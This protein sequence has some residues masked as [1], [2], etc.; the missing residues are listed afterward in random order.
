MSENS[1]WV[2]QEFLRF[3]LPPSWQKTKSVIRWTLILN[4]ITHC[5]NCCLKDFRLFLLIIVAFTYFYS[6]WIKYF[7]PSKRTIIQMKKLW[8]NWYKTSKGNPRCRILAKKTLHK[9]SPMNISLLQWC[10]YNNK[11]SYA[12]EILFTKKK[13]FCSNQKNPFQFFFPIY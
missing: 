3:P 6:L 13:S 12:L 9:Y 4:L 10:K 5:G 1:K 2:S 7:L 11:K 8:V